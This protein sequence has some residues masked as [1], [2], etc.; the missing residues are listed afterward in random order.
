VNLDKMRDRI[1][2]IVQRD[3]VK[4]VIG[5]EQGS[6]AWRVSPCFARTSEDVEK[7]IFSPLCTQNLVTYLLLEEK[8]PLA[9]GE[10]AP[11]KKTGLFVK[12]CDSRA[13]CQLIQE[14][15]VKREDLIL[16]G[17]PCSGVVDP[18]KMNKVFRRVSGNIEIEEHGEKYTIKSGKTI[19]E[20]AKD[21]L[22]FENCKNCQYQNPLIFDIMIGDEIKSTYKETYANVIE[23]EKKQLP[24]RLK[25]WQQYFDRCIRCYACRNSCPICNCRECMA[26]KLNPT[27]IRR[28]VNTTE[29]MAFH[30]LK[31]YHTA[32]RCIGCG[33]CERAC[34]VNIPLTRLYRRWKRML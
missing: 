27:W 23:L 31:A 29:N 18:R 5:Y 19:K 4:Y 34:P 7:L 21:E 13:V 20:I 26:E 11:N 33:S 1:K 25:Y 24:D 12:G 3:D 17:V 15:A 8:L 9:K 6:Y 30:I 16:I 14:K 2:E 22:L 10:K 32:G 28:E